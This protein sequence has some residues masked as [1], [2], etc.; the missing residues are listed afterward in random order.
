MKEIPIHDCKMI[1]VSSEIRRILIKKKKRS[2][3]SDSIK[4]YKLSRKYIDQCNVKLTSRYV[5]VYVS[6]KTVTFLYCILSE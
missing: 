6:S 1:P 3:S 2:D 4:F 5:I